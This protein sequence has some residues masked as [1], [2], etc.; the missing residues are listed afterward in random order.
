MKLLFAHQPVVAAKVIAFNT[1]GKAYLNASE[2]AF[3]GVFPKLRKP[4]ISSVMSAHPYGTTRLP[5][6][7]FL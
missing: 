5:L 1:A 6:D 7:G 2:V 3:L 4:T